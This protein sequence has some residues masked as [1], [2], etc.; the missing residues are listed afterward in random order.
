[1]SDHSY[2]AQLTELISRNL[3]VEDLKMSNEK[4][5]SDKLRSIVS[6]LLDN[7]MARLLQILY[8]IDVSERHVKEILTETNPDHISIELTSAIMDRMKQKL[9]FRMKYDS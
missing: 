3:Q 7:D 9:F 5:I 8:R 2:N 6:Y 4:E 1:M